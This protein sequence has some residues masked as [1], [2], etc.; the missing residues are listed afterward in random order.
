MNKETQ[1]V[2]IMPTKNKFIATEEQSA[3]KNYRNESNK[4]TNE[5]CKR[6]NKKIRSNN[7]VNGLMGGLAVG[8]IFGALAGDS[9]SRKPEYDTNNTIINYTFDANVLAKFMLESLSVAVAI[10]LVIATIKT[11]SDKKKNQFN[12][13][14]MSRG[15]LDQYF[16]KSLSEFDMTNTRLPHVSYLVYTRAAALVINNMPEPELNRIHAFIKSEITMATDGQPITTTPSDAKPYG[17]TTNTV[18]QIISNHINYNPELKENVLAILH[19][20]KPTTYFLKQNQKV[21]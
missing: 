5:I 3:M 16:D 19:G 2:Y 12:I 18:A 14:I 17:K 4:I 6:I 20:D 15:L 10:A 1:G 11:Q 21:R 8:I 13:E 9:R 7:L